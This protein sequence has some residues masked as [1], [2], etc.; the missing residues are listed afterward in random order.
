M[1]QPGFAWKRKVQ[2]QTLQDLAQIR[3][4]LAAYH[5]SGDPQALVPLVD[6]LTRVEGPVGPLLEAREAYAAESQDRRK[7]DDKLRNAQVRLCRAAKEAFEATR[8]QVGSS[9]RP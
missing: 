3:E 1:S 4:A 9:A 5:A 2:G 7:S 6:F 8:A